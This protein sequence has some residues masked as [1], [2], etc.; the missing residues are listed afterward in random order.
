[1]L[2]EAVPSIDNHLWRVSPDGR[3]ETTWKIRPGA[4]W[5]DGTPFT[6]DD[7]VFT[8]QVGMDDELALVRYPAYA[9]IDTIQAPDARTLVITWKRPFIQADSLFSIAAALP[10]PKHVL[11]PTYQ[12]DKS[13]LL[14]LP[15][16]TSAYVGT[17]PYKVRDWVAGSRA[18]LDAFDA[19]T[20]GRPKIDRI[21]VRFILD[22]STLI[23]NILAGEVDLN[24][25]RGISLEQALQASRQWPDGKLD[26]ALQS[27]YALYPQ[28]LNPNPPVVADAQ[29]RRALLHAIDRQQMTNTFMGG[30]TSV[31]DTMVTP[32]DRE[33]GEIAARVVNYPFDPR[34]ATQLIDSLGYTRGLDGTYRD[35]AG[36]RLGIEVRTGAGDE[37]QEKLILTIADY[38][39]QAGV[40]AEPLIFPAQRSN[41]LEFRQTRP[42]FEMVRQP[43]EIIRFHGS[44][45][46]LPENGYRGNNRTRYRNA[47]LDAMIDRYFVTIPWTERMEVL[48]QIVHHLSDQLVAMG[49]LYD[50][51]PMLI[52][53]RLL[54]VSAAAQSANAIEWDVRAP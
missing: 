50:A 25:G 17:G 30:L 42:A 48:G 53:N 35:A 54:N 43:S 46:P 16:W 40:A 10:I 41:D 20:L 34:R 28:F 11:E 18:T 52:G 5:H 39:Q 3:M 15:Y 37:L 32:S 22:P 47:E 26:T 21:E 8:L 4:R 7:L 29:F 13:R 23:A 31:A 12:E 24:M 38:W 9:S 49:V 6:S 45:T 27:W 19:Y 44:S 51:Q 14:A 1:Q 2:A 36:Q 33:Y